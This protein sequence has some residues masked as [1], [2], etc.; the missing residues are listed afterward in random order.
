MTKKTKIWGGL[1]ILLL[2]ALGLGKAFGGGQ[3]PAD[4]FSWDT[5]SRGDVRETINA[6][7]EIQA[8]VKI[9]IGTSVAGEIKILH[10]QD[11]QDVK[12]GDLLVTLDRE[13]L[14]QQLAQ[15]EAAV[16]AS[17][18]DAARL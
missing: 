11:G 4:A 1:A 17:R 16:A 8:R 9:N 15:A 12:A 10:V 3:D 6:S 7:G 18:Q 2:A 5:A 13:R 14:Q